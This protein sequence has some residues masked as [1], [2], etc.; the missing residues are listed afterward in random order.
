MGYIGDYTEGKF[1][2]K[3]ELLYTLIK[4]GFSIVLSPKA[5][6]SLSTLIYKGK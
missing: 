4:E 1:K 6:S 3:S 2:K 5:V